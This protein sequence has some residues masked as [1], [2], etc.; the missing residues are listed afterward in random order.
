MAR[1]IISVLVVLVL[2]AC[3]GGG[4][5]GSGS[6]SDAAFVNIDVD[7][8]NIETGQRMRIFIEIADILDQGVSI[9]IRHPEALL[10]V[11][12]SSILRVGDGSVNF[13]PTED[14]AEDTGGSGDDGGDD[15]GSGDTTP[16]PSPT[17]S[18]TP[19]SSG[20]PSGDSV[21]YDR[22]F[23][24][25][26]ISPSDLGDEGRGTLEFEVEGA[27]ALEEGLI[28]VDADPDNPNVANS[29]EFSTSDPEFSMEDEISVSVGD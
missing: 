3:G 6:S 9:K 12:N 25:Y 28:E 7:N 15:G 18:S 16:S 14:V 4:G 17:P 11:P 19:T 23:L 2:F 21:N 8:R 27:D 24:V 26:F 5:G 10:Y 20:T 29:R 13:G 22:R 1:F